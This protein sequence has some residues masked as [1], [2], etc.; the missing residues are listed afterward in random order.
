MRLPRG[1]LIRHHLCRHR[2][3]CSSISLH[4]TKLVADS[5]SKST[6]TYAFVK[7]VV[8]T[9]HRQHK[10]HS[11]SRPELRSEGTPSSSTTRSSR[12]SADQPPPYTS[13]L[14]HFAVYPRLRAYITKSVLSSSADPAN[15]DSYFSVHPRSKPSLL[16]A[17]PPPNSACTHYLASACSPLS[18]DM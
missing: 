10:F 7:R 15:C 11:L 1:V 12:H 3:P 18:T 16:S 6:I 4:N 5:S 8:K 13:S 9:S 17:F 14:V 2:P